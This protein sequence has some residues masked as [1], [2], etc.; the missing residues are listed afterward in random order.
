MFN[1]VQLQDLI[2]IDDY[3]YEIPVTFRSD[4]RVPA[5]VFA[6]K[7]MLA[8]IVQDKSLTQL[9]NTATLPGV[10][11]QAL[12]MPDI[13][14]G[15]G[16]PI[17]GVVA[18][19]CNAGG[20][21][22]PGGIGYDI[23][24]GVRLLVLDMVASEIKGYEDA[25]A[26]ALFRDVPSGVGHSGELKLSEQELDD[27]LFKG[28]HWALENGYALEDD[29]TFCEERGAMLGANPALISDL[30]KRRGADQ[31]GTLGSGNHFLEV[32]KVSHIFDKTVAEAFGLQED[33]VVVMIHCGS[34]G[35]GHQVCTDFVR[36]MSHEIGNFGYVLPDRELVCAPVES[37]IGRDYYAAMCAA[38]N[39]AWANRQLITHAVRGAIKKVF[40]PS[41][42]ARLLYDI[43]HNMGKK[44]KHTINGIDYDLLVH[45]KG[46]TRSF[47]S[48]RPELPEKYMHVGQPVL[49]P[50]TMGTSSYVLVGAQ[51]AMH[52]TFGSSC[53]G[54][55]RKL[56][57]TA[58]KKMIGIA[59]LKRLL[60]QEGV[61]VRCD[62]AAGLLEE[63]PAA[64]KDVDSV[65]E[66]VHRSEIAYKVAQTKP[67]IVIKGG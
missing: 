6:N 2:A 4:M 64:Y 22:S 44:E 43:S 37:S 26:N 48:G 59:E 19:D 16:F 10:V 61:I 47:A 14:Q 65:V 20:V 5:R 23:N 36:I 62:S 41:A 66:V 57:R 53:H 56:S 13:H 42:H 52:K 8:D 12:A 21:I 17:G 54:A 28:V 50:G 7:E 3:Q 31:L 15:Y 58:A 11:L 39:F 67:M 63:A 55:G 9:V 46:A 40:G 30:A 35:L 29:I 1:P 27:V 18:T 25:L 32:Q 45:R 49:I 51:R 60:A 34:R 38:A 33:H 24:C